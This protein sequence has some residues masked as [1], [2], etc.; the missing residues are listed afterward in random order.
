MTVVEEDDAVAEPGPALLPV[1][2]GD[3]SLAA[4]AV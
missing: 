4:R 3:V 1:V 2:C